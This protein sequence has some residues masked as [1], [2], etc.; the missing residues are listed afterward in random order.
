M[1]YKIDI[2]NPDQIIVEQ[3]EA[4]FELEKYD[5]C[6]SDLLRTMKIIQILSKYQ[7]LFEKE[8]ALNTFYA[9]AKAGQINIASVFNLINLDK[10]KFLD[11][12]KEMRYFDLI[13]TDEQSDIVLTKNGKKF[14]QSLGMDI[15]I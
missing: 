1:A 8:Y 6:E 9:I 11:L 3:L 15:F 4:E 10:E 2:N 7:E 5:L 12:I 14:A 13:D